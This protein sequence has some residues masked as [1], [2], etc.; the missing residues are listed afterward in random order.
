MVSGRDS[1]K[2]RPLVEAYRPACGKEILHSLLGFGARAREAG[3][4]FLHA[5]EDRSAPMRRLAL[6]GL[7]AIGAPKETLGPVLERAATDR[8]REVREYARKLVGG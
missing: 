7:K 3:P 5:F 2:I 6:R 4:V 1:W 8:S